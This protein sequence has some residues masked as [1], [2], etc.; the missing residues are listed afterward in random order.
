MEA[1][2][3]KRTLA[4]KVVTQLEEEEARLI[5]MLKEQQ[6]QQQKAYMM[7]Q[8]TIVEGGPSIG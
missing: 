5:E 8:E 3:L 6:V 2:A 4:E 7:L 1:E